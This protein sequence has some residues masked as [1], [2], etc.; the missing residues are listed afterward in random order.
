MA[1]YSLAQRTTVTTITAASWAAL[2]PATNEAAMMEWGYFNGAATACVVGL[3]RT[4]N[5]PTLTGGVA[6]L[7]EDEGRPTGL[8][9]SAVA[10]GTAPTVPTQFFR[11]FSLAALIGAAVVYTFPRGIVLPAGGQA[12]CAWNITAN[13]AVVDIHCVVDE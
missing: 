4:G 3:G 9:Q 11:R 7:A 8:T 1:I 6:F 10:F 12:I 5:T 13:S 2:S